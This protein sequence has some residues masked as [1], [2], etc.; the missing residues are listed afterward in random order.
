MEEA[1][2]REAWNHT[3]RILAMLANTHR[4]PKTRLLSPADFHPMEDRRGRRGG[5]GNLT[6]RTIA[7]IAAGLPKAA[8]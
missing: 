1:R 4:D 6:K 3:A 2:R 8:R 5:R 7:A